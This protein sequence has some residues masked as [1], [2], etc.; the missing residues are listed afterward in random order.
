MHIATLNLTMLS[1]IYN[2]IEYFVQMFPETPS[3][4]S[5]KFELDHLTED[6]IRELL[7]IKTI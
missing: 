7:L 1:K 3:P 2:G 6:E 5:I 4:K